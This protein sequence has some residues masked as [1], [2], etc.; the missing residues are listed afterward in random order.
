MRILLAHNSLYYPSH[1]GG[2]KSNRLLMEALAARGH[3]VRVVARIERFGPEEQ[4]RFLRRLTSMGVEAEVISPEVRLRLNGVDVRTLTLDPHL[5]AFFSRHVAEFDP[6]VI[7]ASTDDPAQILLDIALKAP[8]ARVV[9]LVRA[10]IAAP[11]GPD[12]S[13]PNAARAEMLRRCDGVVGVSEYVAR[14]MSRWGGIPAIHLPISLLEPGEYPNLGGFENPFV[15]LVNPCAVK[16]ISIFLELAD[17][18]PTVRF[19]A[20]PTW[21]TNA[22]DLAALRERPNVTILE[23]VDNIDELLRQT[24]VLLVPSVWAEAR[25]RIVVEAMARGIPVVASDIGGIPEAKLGVPYL[26]PVNP[27]VRY[28]P[29][30]DENMAPIPE[31]PEQAVGPWQTA[32]EGLLTDREHY[33]RLSEQSRAAAL[34]YAQNLSVGPFEKYLEGILQSPERRA[35]SA[36]TASILS[37]EKRKLL[38]LR[39]QQKSWFPYVESQPSKPRLVCFP[40]AGA[41]ALAYRTWIAPLSPAVSVCPVRLPGRETRINEEPLQNMAALVTALEAAIAP[42]LDH[43]FA[44]FGHSM[45]AVIA[46]ELTRSLRRHYKTLPVALHVSGAR[47]PQFRLNWTPPP[48]PDDRELL[49]QLRRLDG[50]PAEVLENPQVMEYALPVLRADTALFRNYVY[51]P[52]PPLPLPIFAYGGRSD[53]NVSAEQVEAWREQTTTTFVRREFEGGH[54]FINSASEEFLRTLLAGLIRAR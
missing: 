14:Y 27:I 44:F 13:A 51:T 41:G 49:E 24:R 18:M 11:F 5:R 29:A 47:A 15:T 26:V 1:G 4:D 3:E 22:A 30:V 54:F 7:I 36:A 42:Y 6:G 40:Y 16:G 19:A 9:Y 8:R 46:F 52:E 37:P 48:V 31:V 33:E 43:P 39:L 35:A 34:E 53:P 23:P 50:V 45:G 25:S 2:D 21:G 12:S 10:T 32:L 17:R 38:A 28:K 20:V